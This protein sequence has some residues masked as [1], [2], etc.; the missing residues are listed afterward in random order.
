MCAHTHAQPAASWTHK[1]I[2]EESRGCMSQA[3]C[4]HSQLGTWVCIKQSFSLKYDKTMEKHPGGWWAKENHL[5]TVTPIFK[6]KVTNSKHTCTCTYTHGVFE[7]TA[8]WRGKNVSWEGRGKNPLK[9]IFHSN[10]N[11]FQTTS[12]LYSLHLIKMWTLRKLKN[13][14]ER[15]KWE[16]CWLT[17]R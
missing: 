9:K 1:S 3:I 14:M 6:E 16:D 4:V 10:T 5:G 8:S 17:G 12:A 11:N 2:L 15:M 7:K 13:K